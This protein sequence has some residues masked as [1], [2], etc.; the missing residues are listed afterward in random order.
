MD[1]S[2][3]GPINSRHAATVSEHPNCVFDSPEAAA[4][5]GWPPKAQARVVKVWMICE[6]EAFVIVD[7]EP[8]HPMRVHCERVDGRWIWMSDITA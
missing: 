3:V 1:I 7:T 2:L 5:S 8:S 4:L 6:T